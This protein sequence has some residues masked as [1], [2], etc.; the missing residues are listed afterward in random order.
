MSRKFVVPI[1][2]LA[3]ASDPVGHEAGDAYYSTTLNAIKTFDGT[4]WTAQSS[5]TLADLDGGSATS[6]YGGI[7]SINAGTATG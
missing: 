1:G 6:N 5:T 3:L 2:L 7:T 4:N